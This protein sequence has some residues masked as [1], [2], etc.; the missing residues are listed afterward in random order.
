MDKKEVLKTAARFRS[1]TL[2][3][4]DLCTRF[5]LAVLHSNTEIEVKDAD[6]YLTVLSPMLNELLLSLSAVVP[7]L[8]SLKESQAPPAGVLLVS[9]PAEA[10][11]HSCNDSEAHNLPFDPSLLEVAKK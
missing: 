10:P 2:K 1:D 9:K 5:Y 8:E 4:V 11:T 6:F 7:L 3:C